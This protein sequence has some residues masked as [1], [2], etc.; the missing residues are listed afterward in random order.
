MVLWPVPGGG[1]PLTAWLARR[2]AA[3]FCAHRGVCA[4][5]DVDAVLLV[6]SELITNAL[7][8]AG[9]VTSFALALDSRGVVVTVSD[10]LTAA[11]HTVRVE[12]DRPGG[13]GWPLVQ[14]LSVAVAVG[15]HGTGKSIRATVPVAALAREPCL[16]DH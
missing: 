10:A 6:V 2:I 5:A 14:R 1:P 4:G 7:R 13:F 12:P 3:D 9:G 16:E 8:H 11:P 15:P